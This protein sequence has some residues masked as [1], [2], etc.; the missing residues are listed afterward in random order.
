MFN[1]FKASKQK[2][3]EK[4]RAEEE[5]KRIQEEKQRAKEEKRRVEEEEKQKM[6]YKRIEKELKKVFVD[7]GLEI[8]FVG[9][10][11]LTLYNYTREAIKILGVD[12][13]ES[14]FYENFRDIYL[15]SKDINDL[16]SFDNKVNKFELKNIFVKNFSEYLNK[17]FDYVET[18]ENLIFDIRNAMQQETL[19]LGNK[20]FNM[21]VEKIK[22]AMIDRNDM[23]TLEFNKTFVLWILFMYAYILNK[24][25]IIL[26]NKQNYLENEELYTITINLYDEKNIQLHSQEELYSSVAAKLFEIY[27]NF[28]LDV[29]DE[30]LKGQDFGALSYLVYKSFK[31][32][33][34]DIS[35]NIKEAIAELEMQEIFNKEKI[36]YFDIKKIMSKIG[37]FFIDDDSVFAIVY[38]SVINLFIDKVDMIELIAMYSKFIEERDNVKNIKKRHDLEKEK[39][40]YLNNDFRKEEQIREDKNDFENIVSG[41][42]FELY[43]KK[44]YIKLGYRVELTKTTGDQGAD[45]ILYK[46]GLKIVVQAKFYSS[47]VGN[48]AVQEVVGAIKFYDADYGIVVTNNL[49]TKSAIELADANNIELIDKFKLDEL[50]E[51]SY[52]N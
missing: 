1:F 21:A 4:R 37:E 5:L 15:I 9:V 25:L 30:K 40:R 42:E 43:L 41:E 17:D 28:Y 20:V 12:I 22:D 50:R 49:F 16:D 39:Y 13:Q 6:E 24:F 14:I 23:I 8:T 34:L 47:P 32:N 35:N 2:K 31:C 36:E 10:N 18:V 27:Q 33:E 46:D 48:K 29:F 19:Y 45:L 7:N 38:G 52:N 44:L 3:E 11:L 26:K 51:K